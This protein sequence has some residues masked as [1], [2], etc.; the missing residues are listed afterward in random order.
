MDDGNTNNDPE[1]N[2]TTSIHNI[3]KT[4]IVQDVRKALSE[5]RLAWNS[6][7]PNCVFYP[8]KLLKINGLSRETFALAHLCGNHIKRH[9]KCKSATSNNIYSDIV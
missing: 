8:S 4:L 1:N 3:S 7:S 2:K 9:S 5:M 6:N